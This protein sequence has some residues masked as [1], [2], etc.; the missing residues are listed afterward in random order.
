MEG[1]EGVVGKAEESGSAA[2]AS[3]HIAS[4][5]DADVGT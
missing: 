4:A 5:V 2:K 1:L 3:F